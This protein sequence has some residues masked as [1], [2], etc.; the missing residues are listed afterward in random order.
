MKT[1][2][3]F[4]FS[5]RPSTTGWEEIFVG[6]PNEHGQGD[7]SIIKPHVSY[8]IV[9]EEK[10]QAN[11]TLMSACGVMLNPLTVGSL[12]GKDFGPDCGDNLDVCVKCGRHLPD[13]ADPNDE[14]A[15]YNQ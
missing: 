3:R 1:Y 5:Y 4:A 9:D 6:P 2:T 15:W 12:E 11:S 7:R 10:T 14:S 8:H 13:Y